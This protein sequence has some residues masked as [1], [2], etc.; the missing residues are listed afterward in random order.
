MTPPTTPRRPTSMAELDE[1]SQ[2]FSTPESRALGLAF[3]PRSTDV[4]VTP[5]AKSGTT[6]LQQIVHGLRTR[7]DMNFCEI[8]EVVPW[9]E[10]AQDLGLDLNAPQPTPRAFK[11][12]LTWHDIPKGGRY[13]VSIRHP[14][15]VLVSF[16]LFFEGWWFEPGTISMT[17]FATERFIASRG[18]WKHLASW[19]EQRADPNVLLLC[20]EDMK[21]D[22]PRT[23]QTVAQFIGVELDTE[24]FEIVVRQSSHPFMMAHESQFD[25]NLV[26]RKRDDVCGLPTGGSSSKVRDSNQR[27]TR[28]VVSPAILDQMELIW[29]EEIAGPFGL[30]NYQALRAELARL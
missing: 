18:Y 19:W 4:F 20:Y 1:H 28:P 12:H 26:R 14:H 10:L 22:L 9:L 24:L 8:T 2:H 11:S 3:L 21:A 27:S 6:W 17:D 16:Y 5:F 30:P 29:Q 7:G 23:V 25:D 15:D 13:I